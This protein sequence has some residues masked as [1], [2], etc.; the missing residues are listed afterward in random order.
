MPLDW[1]DVKRRYGGG[2]LV[3]TVAGHKTLEV[4]GADDA[5]I[6]IRNPLWQAALAR[7]DLEK[8]VALIEDG[9]I[10]RDPGMFVEDYRVYVT[11][12][13]ATSVAHIL[14]DLG[15]LDEDQG[16]VPRC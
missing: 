10:S 8:G 6:H 13:R 2:A 1:S 4:T 9:V 16:L 7:S 12:D 14:H 11:D 15:F 3:P 5:A